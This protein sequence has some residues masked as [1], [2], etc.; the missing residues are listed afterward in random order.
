M[1]EKLD[2]V[3]AYWNGKALMSRNGKVFSAPDWFVKDLPPFEID[4]ELWTKRADFETVI[5]IVNRQNPHDGWKHISYQIF[6]VP[7]QKGGLLE[8]LNVLEKWL[9]KNPN[10]FINIIPQTVCKGSEHLK[11]VLDEVESKGAEGLVVRNPDALYVGKRSKNAL[12]VKS[13]QDDECVVNG[14]TKGK[15]KFEGLVGALLCEW[16]GRT[17]KIG[18]GLSLEDRKVPPL[19]D[20]NITFKYNGLTKYGNPKF[21]VFLRER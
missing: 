17:L 18:S 19:L 2:G 15:G 4:G 1:S 3:R 8:R 20:T 5:S 11:A 12:K 10:K 6:E 21:P 16:Q 7:N 14:Y 13:F 9:A